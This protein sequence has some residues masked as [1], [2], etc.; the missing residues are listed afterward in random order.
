[1]QFKWKIFTSFPRLIFL[2]FLFHSSFTFNAAKLSSFK[3]LF[4]F[5][6]MS[7]AAINRRRCCFVSFFKFIFIEKS[8]FGS[9]QPTDGVFYCFLY[10]FSLEIC[11]NVKIALWGLHSIVVLLR[12]Y[13]KCSLS[14]FFKA[15][16]SK[17]YDEHSDRKV[18]W[19]II[20]I[21]VIRRRYIL[22]KDFFIGNSDIHVAG[23]ND[24]SNLSCPILFSKGFLDCWVIF[25]EIF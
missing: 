3:A 18:C 14:V 13:L 21:S 6:K 17:M 24:Q 8:V 12:P 19:L 2:R 25:A 15:K 23:I 16:M 20:P 7:I 1:M 9:D 5:N 11:I 10:R 4:Y 22:M